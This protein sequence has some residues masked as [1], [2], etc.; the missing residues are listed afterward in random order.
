MAL[1]RVSPSV[2]RGL[3]E[4]PPSKSYTHRAL[5]LATVASDV[6]ELEN[7]LIADD[8]IASVNASR[9][10]GCSVD[11]ENGGRGIIVKPPNP[12]RCPDDVIDVG[13]SGTTL[14]LYTSLSSL[15]EA[16]YSVLTG[17]TSIRRRPME[18]L[19]R[20]LR[21]LGIEAWSTRLNGFAPI[22]VKGGGIRGRDTAV[23]GSVSSQFIS[24]LLIACQKAEN[25]ITINVTGE[26]VS[27]TYIDATIEVIRLFGGRVEKTPDYRLYEI[28]PSELKLRRFKTPGDFS[29][30]SF[31]V[32][33]AYLTGGEVE[34][35]N[36]TTALPQADAA[37]LEI[38]EAMGARVTRLVEGFRVKGMERRGGF[39]F[40]LRDSPDLVPVVAVMAALTPGEVKIS[41]VAHARYK[42]SDR[43]GN[44]AH[45]LE[46]LGVY[47]KAVD[48]GI[49]IHG[50]EELEGGVTV[51]TYRDH[52]I[53]MAFTVLGLA[54]RKGVMVK[55]IE[56]AKVSYP[57][58]VDD[59]KKLGADVEVF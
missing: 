36:L 53:A 35:R 47:A 18:P 23:D 57:G 43:I 24:S 10:L 12:L 22:V 19:L 39:T 5:A 54:C 52:R 3:V 2:V 13:N 11:V 17:D 56:S 51:E 7:P 46:K 8:T 15:T 42:E 16:G 58:F 28:T 4:A 34:I 50:C 44:V 9:R 48:D 1:I 49:I 55:E 20:A 31:L 27:R 26:V 21:G 30:A 29:S 33:A 40:S 41:D 32:A 38:A 37:I 59:L 14:R 25:P 45:E 6:T